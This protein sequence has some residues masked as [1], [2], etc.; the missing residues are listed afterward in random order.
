MVTG[1]SR[2]VALPLAALILVLGGMLGHPRPD[3]ADAQGVTQDSSGTPDTCGYRQTRPLSQIR[4]PAIVE[5]SALVASQQWPG[6]Y[7]TFNDSKNTPTLYAIDMD[8]RPRGTF[9]VPNASNVDWE[10]M[11]LGRDDDGGYALYIGDVGD[12]RAARSESVIYRVPEPTPAPAEGPVTAGLT[13][14]ATA[15]RF[16][17]W[18]SPRNVEAM[19]VHPVTGEIALISRGLGSFG[20]VYGFPRPPTAESPPVA[21]LTSVI[22]AQVLGLINEEATDATISPD[23]RH[24]VVRTYAHALVYDVPDDTP[25]GRIWSQKPRVYQLQ[26]G[27][28]GEGLTFRPNSLD[29]VTI[30]EGAYPSLYLTEWSCSSAE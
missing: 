12:N 11:Q 21:E 8:G 15:L 16:T 24:V 29:L 13:A 25:L 26:D 22:D 7:W 18:V 23:G 20:L 6:I 4:D 5:A 27:P 9:Q 30:G 28:K 17:Y 10:A 1:V 19:V 14:P 2:R 3:D